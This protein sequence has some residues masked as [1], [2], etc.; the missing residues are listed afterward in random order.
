M[1]F[2]DWDSNHPGGGSIEDVHRF[3]ETAFTGFAGA[4]GVALLCVIPALLAGVIADEHQRKTLHYLLASRMSSAEIVLGK[5]GARL[6][7]AGVLVVMG[8][9]VVCLV[10]LF[11]GLDPWEVFYVY[12][13]T[14]SMVLFIAGLSLLVSVLA[15]R[16]RDA[17]LTT[18]VLV[19]AWLFLPPAVRSIYDDIAYRLPWVPPVNEVVL[20]SNPWSAW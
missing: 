18:Y 14:A 13:G 4:Q 5:L 12:A 16:P 19:A 8:V 17:I 20:A 9:P 3:A 15:R 11:G 10:A 6:L 1:Q 7:H 2:K